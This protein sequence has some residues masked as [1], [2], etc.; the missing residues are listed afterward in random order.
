MTHA[1]AAQPGAR[2]AGKTVL[3][4]GAASGIGLAT[5]HRFAREGAQVVLSDIALARAQAAADALTAEGARALALAH[6]VADESAWARVLDRAIDWA[7][8]LDVLVNNAGIAI[9]GNAEDASL[10]DWRRTQSINLDGVFLGTRA[11][12]GAMKAHGGAIVNVSSIEGMI[13]EP[14]IAAYNASKGGVR[15]FTK[16]AA[17]HCANHGYAIRINSIH[18]GFVATPMVAGAVEFLGP[19]A[20]P[21]FQQE[22]LSRIPMKRLALPEEIAAGISF[23]AS[24]DASYMTGAELVMDGGYTAR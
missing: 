14:I 13:G 16:S 18:P 4:T 3:V 20:G 11:A 1:S 12:I 8:A 15:I 24:D 21:A 7:G 9:V 23:L 19:Q 22:V 6:D 5:A 10:A 2:F 17:L